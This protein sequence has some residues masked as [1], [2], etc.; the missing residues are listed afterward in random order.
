MNQFEEILQGGDLR[1]IGESNRIGS[2]IK[3]QED[4]DELFEL[5]FHT[6]R[7]VAMRAADSVEKITSKYP[8][9]LVH[10]KKEILK[11][12]DNA[13]NIEMK[14]HLALIVSRLRLNDNEVGFVWQ[15]LT[16]WANNH[17][18]SKIVRVNSIQGLFNL[19]Q[20]HGELEK[21][22]QLT[23]DQVQ[24]EKIPSINARLRK[25]KKN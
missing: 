13:N 18:E 1:S 12:F 7:K 3:N 5:L 15:V 6:D 2:L 17:R 11:F 16:R 8:N 22:F 20:Q 10:H 9:Y 23:L 25:L 24:R 21:D 19:L 4:F 14:W